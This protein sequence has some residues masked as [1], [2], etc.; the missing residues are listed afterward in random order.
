M[1]AI[2]LIIG[3]ADTCN[4]G[5]F[6]FFAFPRIDRY[7]ENIEFKKNV[8]SIFVYENFF[9]IFF[10]FIEMLIIFV[11]FLNYFFCRQ[12]TLFILYF[13]I[14]YLFFRFLFVPYLLICFVFINLFCNYF[15]WLLFVL[16]LIF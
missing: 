10:F 15:Y 3:R 16:Y 4:I 5:I 8:M 6:F 7:R 14:S 1:A 13:F 9:R 12:I 11:L 2:A